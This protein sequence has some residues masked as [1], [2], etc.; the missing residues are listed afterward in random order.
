MR[1]VPLHWVKWLPAYLFQFAQ[2]EHFAEESPLI[3]MRGTIDD[4]QPRDGR[5]P[6]MSH[7]GLPMLRY[8]NPR[9]RI[10]TGSYTFLPSTMFGCLS[11]LFNW[12]SSMLRNSSH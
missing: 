7:H 2:P 9:M 12:S 5:F 3:H 10:S 1:M 8:W 6:D 4:E 11:A